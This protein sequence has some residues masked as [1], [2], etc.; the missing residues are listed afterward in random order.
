M[1]NKLEEL[2]HAACLCCAAFELPCSQ[3]ARLQL[4]A[5]Y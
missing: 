4:P 5:R 1:V 3:V 2:M